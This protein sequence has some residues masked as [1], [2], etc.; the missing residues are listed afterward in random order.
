MAI[1]DKKKGVWGLDQVYNKENQGSIWEY[2]DLYAQGN[3][4]LWAWGLNNYGM[5]GQNNRTDY[6]SPVQIP[7]TTWSRVLRGSNSQSGAIN[8][9]GELWVWGWNQYGQLA[10]NSRTQYSSPVQVPGSWTYGATNM[11]GIAAVNTSGELWIWGDNEYGQLGQGNQTKYSSPVQVPGTTWVDV[12]A[13]KGQ[14]KATKTDGTL[15]VWG[16][17]HRGQLGVNDTT[18]YSSPKQVPGTTW[19]LS[20]NTTTGQQASRMLKTDGTMWSWG[21][22]GGLGLNDGVKYSSPVQI[23]GGGTDWSNIGG[24][25]YQAIAVKTD[26]TLWMWGTNGPGALGQNDRTSRSSPIQVG[27]DN[28]WAVGVIPNSGMTLAAKIDGTLWGWGNNDYGQ[29]GQNSNIKYSSP[30]QIPGSWSAK[31]NGIN[32]A[33][34]G[35]FGIKP[36]AS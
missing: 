29:L 14:V 23:H 26:G 36:I 24:S 18:N 21:Y 25:S 11:R 27:S 34:A 35:G 22:N 10:Q 32:G 9:S 15:W 17:N 1:T 7:G 3:G 30:V 8:T 12:A 2:Y 31:I 19:T 13:G 5:L 4:E 16:Y 20:N 33:N 6:S 28:T